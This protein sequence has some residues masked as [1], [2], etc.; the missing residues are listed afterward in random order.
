MS[1]G[2][3]VRQLFIHHGVSDNS[4]NFAAWHLA[5][6][7]LMERRWEEWITWKDQKRSCIPREDSLKSC[8]RC[9]LRGRCVE[10]KNQ[11]QSLRLRSGE[12]HFYR[13]APKVRLV[14]R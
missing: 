14:G 13:L 5:Q 4:V 8:G 6:E 10:K 11:K 12:Q 3:V 1:V 7:S 2:R 9:L